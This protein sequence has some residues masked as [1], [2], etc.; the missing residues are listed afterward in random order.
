MSLS[1]GTADLPDDILEHI[2][3]CPECREFLSVHKSLGEVLR[4]SSS[5]A[6]RQPLSF[7]E[8][9][10]RVRLRVPVRGRDGTTLI[11]RGGSAVR[12]LALTAAVVVAAAAALSFLPLSFGGKGGYEVAVAGVNPELIESG[13][14]E[15]AF[16]EAGLSAAVMEVLDCNPS[17]MV[18]VSGLASEDEAKKAA[19]VIQ[20]AQA[21]YTRSKEKFTDQNSGQTVSMSTAS[22]YV[23]VEDGKWVLESG[24]NDSILQRIS[25]DLASLERDTTVSWQEYYGEGEDAILTGTED[26]TVSPDGSYS[27]SRLCPTNLGWAQSKETWRYDR[28]GALI[29][30]S[31]TD[32]LGREYDI[33]IHDWSVEEEQL[34]RFGVYYFVAYTE[35]G[36]PHHTAS[37]VVPAE[38]GLGLPH[39]ADGM[40]LN[41]NVPNGFDTLTSITFGI[42]DKAPVKLEIYNSGSQ[43]VRTLVNGILPAGEHTIAWDARDNAG[44]RVRCYKFMAKLTVG[45]YY[46]T[47]VMAQFR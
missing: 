18:L 20:E 8:L 11:P 27:N 17:C 29:G 39:L 14:I 16:L 46:H 36:V 13:E 26:Y 42:P 21:I 19:A 5:N 7:E 40:Y 24:Y 15:R 10:D 3:Q 31:I 4:V 44:E 34:K 47:I 30:R 2:E 25:I 35:L 28:S 43:L 12:R 6:T 32:T 33:N 23:G 37:D 22:L 1:T 9:K 41:Q 38:R 45:E